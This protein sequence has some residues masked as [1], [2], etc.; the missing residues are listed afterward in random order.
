MTSILWLGIG[1]YFLSGGN[2]IASADSFTAIQWYKKAAVRSDGSKPAHRAQL[3]LGHCY[4]KGLY[5]GK[6]DWANASR[7]YLTA[8]RNR[9]IAAQYA[10]GICHL[11]GDGVPRD[12]SEGLYWLQRAADQHFAHAQDALGKYHYRNGNEQEGKRWW[13][14]AA[15]R[16]HETAELRLKLAGTG[17]DAN[18]KDLLRDLS[19]PWRNDHMVCPAKHA[20][21]Q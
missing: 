21:T 8:A 4:A 11:S 7:W 20:H 12:A 6:A 15:M 3:M 10:I 18:K 19:R 5:S 16:G 2:G 13:R 17:K 14:R 1:D 9:N